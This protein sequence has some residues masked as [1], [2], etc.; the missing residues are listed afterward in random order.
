MVNSTVP[1]NCIT[2]PYV[3]II[4]FNFIYIL[5][6]LFFYLILGVTLFGDSDVSDYDDS[7]EMSSNKVQRE[8]KVAVNKREKGENRH[9][10]E[11]KNAEFQLR[12]HNHHCGKWFKRL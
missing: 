3:S 8:I 1:Y 7:L 12:L 6:L 10:D 5:K 11:E 2:I 4:W 9:P